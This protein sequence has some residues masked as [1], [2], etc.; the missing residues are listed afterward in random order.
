MILLVSALLPAACTYTNSGNILVEPL[1]D[2]PAIITVHTNLDTMNNPTVTSTDTLWVVFEAEVN[3]GELYYVQ[4]ILE[5]TVVYDSVTASEVD[6][7][8]ESFILRDSFGIMP[9]I[10]FDPGHYSL[11]MDFYYS[12]NTNS[13]SDRYGYE[14]ELKELEYSVIVEGDDQ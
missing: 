13:L 2:D 8:F 6:T 1:E 3:N 7:L 9:S 5:D 14:S 11:Y 10:S 4:C 12:S